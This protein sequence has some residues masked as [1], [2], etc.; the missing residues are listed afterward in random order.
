MVR[1]LI[2]N[3]NPHETRVALLENG[4][5][6]EFFIERMGDLDMAGNIYKGRVRR[7][8]PGIQAAFVDI[9]LE[10]ASFIHVN[11]VVGPENSTMNRLLTGRSET[12]LHSDGSSSQ[13]PKPEYERVIG[14]LLK[15]GQEIMVD[16]AKSPVGTKGPRVTTYISIPGRYLVMMPFSP[17]MGVSRKIVDQNERD[18]LREL[19]DTIGPQGA[20]WIVR[21]AGEGVSREKLEDEMFFLKSLWKSIQEKF[22][23]VS[24]P[25]LLH[26]ELNVALRAV[27]D[28]L[29]N[30]AEALIT[31]SPKVY[32]SILSFLDIHMPS[33]QSS[34]SLYTGDEPI[35]DAY[36]LEGEI[37]RALK[38]K[39][40]LKSGGY[41]V[42]DQTEALCAIDVN[43]GRYVGRHNQDETILKINLEAAREIAY[44]V[45]LRDIS[46]I[47]IIDFIDMVKKSHQDKIYTTLQKMLSKDRSKTHVLPISE[48]GLVQMTRKRVRQSLHSVMSEPCFYCNGEGYL[49]SRQTL[50]YKI[51][52]D[53]LTYSPDLGDRR[54]TIKVNP[55]I[56]DLL[57]HEEHQ[58]IMD[59]EDRLQKQVVVYP[60]NDFHLE[61][62]EI[63]ENAH[64]N[65]HPSNKPKIRD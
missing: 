2:V 21:T 5:V 64:A 55:E 52:R 36:N 38:R 33:L 7:V 15:E 20:G 4:S 62:F 3:T 22:K 29:T 26:K 47:I 1:K 59:L 65:H 56:A 28:L 23:V 48:L 61:Q 11:D 40:W 18:R 58:M 41:I 63:V 30:E 27:R 39:V 45:R 13:S 8:L 16:V 51:Y 31:D 32:Q 12:G 17:H 35:F 42:I 57:H 25:R 53:V 14:D 60:Q 37:S 24:A 34:V 10:Q 43:T 50:C 44:Q 19:I 46:G 54:V 9:G 6:V 49:S